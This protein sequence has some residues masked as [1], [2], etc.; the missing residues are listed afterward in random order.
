VSGENDPSGEQRWF[1]A[2]LVEVKLTQQE[3]GETMS[4]VDISAPPG[5]IE[6]AGLSE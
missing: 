4:I 2:N 5:D 1:F 6:A 3:S